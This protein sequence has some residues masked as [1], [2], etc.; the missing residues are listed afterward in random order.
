RLI[1]VGRTL[2]IGEVTLY[3]EGLDEPVAHVVGSYSIPP[4]ARR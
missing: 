3:S 4:D 2:A 1:K